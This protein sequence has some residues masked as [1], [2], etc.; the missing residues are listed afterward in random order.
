[1]ASVQI[2]CKNPKCNRRFRKPGESRR[3]YCEDCRPPRDRMPTAELVPGPAVPIGP[4]ECERAVR[5]ELQRS[6]RLGSVP[7]VLACRLARQLDDATLTGA[8]AASLARQVQDL[9]ASALDGV[10]P[11]ADFV[12]D[13]ADRRRSRAVGL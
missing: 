7:G 10:A 9:M 1:M 5:G 3:L 2:R 13:L 4:G 11:P 6:E 8:Q 12:D